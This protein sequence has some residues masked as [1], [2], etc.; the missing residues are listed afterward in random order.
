MCA[1]V[2]Q[3]G[4]RRLPK[5]TE[6][7]AE[8]DVDRWRSGSDRAPVAIEGRGVTLPHGALS[9]RAAEA[10]PRIADHPNVLRRSVDANRDDD[11][12]PLKMPASIIES[13]LTL[14]T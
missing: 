7:A 5:A 4:N 8:G 13:P 14:S 3:R 9:R 12:H 2:K 1:R 10:V 6:L 11:R